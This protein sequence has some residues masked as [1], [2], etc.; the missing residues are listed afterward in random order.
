MNAKVP[1][2]ILTPEGS[3]QALH[4]DVLYIKEG[5]LNYQYWMAC[6]P[7]PYGNDLFENPILRVSRNGLDW[8]PFYGAPDPLVTTDSNEFHNAD[9]DLVFFNGTL[10]VFYMTANRTDGSVKFSYVKTY[11]GVNWGKP[12]GV[13]SGKWSVSPAVSSMKN[14]FYMWHIERDPN[15]RPNVSSLYRRESKDLNQWSGKLE[16]Q[17][18]IPGYVVWHI[19]VIENNK[20]YEALVAAY[21]V[22]LDPS[23]CKLFYFTSEDGLIFKNKINKI[24]IGPSILGWDNRMIY[25]STFIKNHDGDMLIWYSAASWSFKTGI[26]FLL[27]KDGKFTDLSQEYVNLKISTILKDCVGLMRYFYRKLLKKSFF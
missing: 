14:G 20:I 2:K 22:H 4:P 23:V 13:F 6:T 9:T 17:I 15:I 1:L 19:D 21:P 16:C 27:Y 7:Y 24:F 3:G 11:D 18:A 25:R 26:G 8:L 5:F 10:Y 12:V